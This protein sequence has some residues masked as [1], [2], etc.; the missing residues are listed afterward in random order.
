[1]KSAT[2]Q[3]QRGES[4]QVQQYRERGTSKDMGGNRMFL[5]H[6]AEERNKAP[7]QGYERSHYGENQECYQINAHNKYLLI[8]HLQRYGN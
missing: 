5:S 6:V 4:E 8:N 1:M 2:F 7:N 3:L